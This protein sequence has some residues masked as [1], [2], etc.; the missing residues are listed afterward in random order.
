MKRSQ[1][2]R[3]SVA[4]WR[5]L[6]TRQSASGDSVAAF[7]RRERINAQVFRRWQARLAERNR[8]AKAMEAVTAD[9]KAASFID[10]AGRAQLAEA[11]R[12]V[13]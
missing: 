9:I 11:L 12:R 7:C 8:D 4:E 1:R 6:M 13:S 5:A 2:M 10:L 3:R